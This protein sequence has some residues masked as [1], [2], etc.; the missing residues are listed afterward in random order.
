MQAVILCGGLGTRLKSVVT[1]IPKPMAP[2]RNFPFL[3]YIV[4]HLKVYGFDKFLFLTGYKSKIIEEYFSEYDFS[5]ENEPLG[6]GGALFN[7]FEKLQDEFFLINGDT[8]FDIDFEIFNDYIKI[9]SVNSA[10]AL[11]PTK[12][13]ERYG[14]VEI[15]DDFCIKNFI[16]KS[17]LDNNLADG[18]INSGIYY[19]KKSVLEKY[20]SGWDN[21]FVSIEKEIFPKLVEIKELKGLPMGGLFIDIG[22]PE[23]YEKAQTLIPQRV[24]DIKRS[25]LFIDRDGTIIE[26]KG[27]TF[28]K[29]LTFFSDTV[30]LVRKYKNKGYYIFVVTNQAGV[31]KGKFTEQDTVTTNNVIKDYYSEQN[32]KIDDFIYCPFHIDG[33]IEK[34]SKSSVYRKPNSGMVLELGS[35]YKIDYKK[36]LFYGDNVKIDKINLPYLVFKQKESNEKIY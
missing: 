26:D 35:K 33:I 14:L 11:F 15:E 20:Y 12:N 32:I 29:N 1:D 31:A 2:V 3:H 19:F 18:F 8:F 27:Y 17:N 30:D 6:T 9:N 22:I 34:Y 36:S 13:I 24:K 23:D 16:E 25:A 28:G 7:A 4:E 5:I 10:I 21:N